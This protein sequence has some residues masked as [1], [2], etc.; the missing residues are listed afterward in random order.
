MIGV[1]SQAPSFILKDQNGEDVGLSSFGIR[2]VLLSFHPLAWTSVCSEQMKDLD[3]NHERFMSLGVTPLGLSVDPVP[4]K[5]AWADNLEIKKLKILSDF[6]P[7]GKIADEYGV[8]RF[9]NG[10]SE[11][12]NIIVSSEGIVVFAKLYEIK[13]LPD[14]EEIFAFIENNRVN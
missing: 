12:A 9:K 2:T 1:S 6:W 10:F 4:S 7:H 11:R 14:I 8:F 13:Q 5:K 3:L